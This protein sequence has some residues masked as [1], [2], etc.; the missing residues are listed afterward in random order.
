M[1]GLGGH[2][3]TTWRHP[4]T[5]FL[6]PNELVA[7]VPKAR[8]LLYGYESG[9]HS[10]LLEGQNLIRLKGLA[11]LFLSDLVNERLEEDV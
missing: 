6:W 10:T 1:H 8:I 7:H 11:E 3:D 9:I 2:P 4:I 5:R